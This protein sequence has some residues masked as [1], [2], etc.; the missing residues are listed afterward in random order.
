MALEKLTE[1]LKEHP[2]RSYVVVNLVLVLLEKLVELEFMCP[3]RRWYTEAFFCL[4]LIMPMLIA[5]NFGVYLRKTKLWSD[6]KTPKRCPCLLNGCA[7][8]LTCAV[9]SV[10][11]LILFFGDGRYVACLI[12]PLQEDYVES[13][14]NPPWEWCDKNQT[15]TDE[16]KHVQISFYISK[17]V[18]FAF[19]TIILFLA[20]CHQCL[21]RQCGRVYGRCC[22]TNWDQDRVDNCIR[23]CSTYWDQ[24]LVNNCIR[25]CSTS[26]GCL[27]GFCG[28]YYKEYQAS[29][30]VPLSSHLFAVMIA[31]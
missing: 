21:D 1:I 26:C 15:L 2:W 20:L 23:C 29:R 27:D 22:S 13:S 17:I 19:I 9:P 24:D 4:Y 30:S 31:I 6:S 5:L 16:Q 28:G 18:V 14:E 7:K 25:S 11:W 8:L 12:T 3:C 10:F